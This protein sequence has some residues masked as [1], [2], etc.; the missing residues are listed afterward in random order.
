MTVLK[1][2]KVGIGTTTPY[3][4]LHV[5]GKVRSDSGFN[6]NNT[7][8]VGGTFNFYND[9]TAGNVIQIVISGGIITNVVTE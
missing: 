3:E 2:G 9:G 6:F 1:D 5:I 8:G 4:T 7:D